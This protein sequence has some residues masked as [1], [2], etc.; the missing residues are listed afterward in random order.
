MCVCGMSECMCERVSVCVRLC[1]FE[2]CSIH[3]P[4]RVLFAISTEELYIIYTSAFSTGLT[5]P[6]L[7][8]VIVFVGIEVGV[9]C[10]H[11]RDCGRVHIMLAPSLTHLDG[12]IIILSD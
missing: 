4:G 9:L 12:F 6:F 11:L 5:V 10:S 2:H 7:C 3:C 8:T 1:V